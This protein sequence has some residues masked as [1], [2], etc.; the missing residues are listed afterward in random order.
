MH[1]RKLANN[2]ASPSGKSRPRKRSPTSTSTGTPTLISPPN[3]T[4]TTTLNSPI[5][6]NEPTSPLSWY[7]GISATT[8]G[9]VTSF[10]APVQPTG[11]SSR[12]FNFS[13]T[14]QPTSIS[15]ISS[16][17]QPQPTLPNRPH[18][19]QSIPI[20]FL[21]NPVPQSPQPFTFSSPAPSSPSPPPVE[22]SSAV[23][24]LQTDP[25]STLP[26]QS[27]P[28]YRLASPS[29]PPAP[30]P[31]HHDLSSATRRSL[32][33]RRSYST[34]SLSILYT[35]GESSSLSTS[36][37]EQ[38]IQP[39]QD[40]GNHSAGFSIGPSTASS[41]RS[42]IGDS[43]SRSK[44]SRIDT[45]SSTP[46]DP[47][48]PESTINSASNSGR[49]GRG[50]SINTSRSR[51]SNKAIKDEQQHQ[52]QVFAT[53]ELA[54]PPPP[55]RQVSLRRTTNPDLKTTKTGKI[56]H[57]SKKAGVNKKSTAYN[58]FLQQQSKYFA[59]H[60]PHLTPQQVNPNSDEHRNRAQ[61]GE[62][63][64]ERKTRRERC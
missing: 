29:R 28:Q 35:Q 46:T 49:G 61:N 54:P 30:S 48:R 1:P 17:S 19:T 25:S 12:S 45:S 36:T 24:T 16:G 32:S 14:A 11:N 6:Q 18:R 42:S 59:K 63:E 38:T 47:L 2:P 15:S 20:S 21:I 53:E 57:K 26:H 55:P 3:T 51:S 8:L 62:T 27:S 64:K 22:P 9:S 50:G 39:V 33:E 10:D 34:S 40:V 44:V 60:H 37:A 58:R 56:L 13:S 23:V 7:A 43:G 52:Q 31:R 4:T 41:K 5:Q